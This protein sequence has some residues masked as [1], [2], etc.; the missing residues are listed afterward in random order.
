MKYWLLLLLASCTSLKPAEPI[1]VDP[2]EFMPKQV[3]NDPIIVGDGLD[4]LQPLPADNPEPKPVPEEASVVEDIPA[5]PPEQPSITSSTELVLVLT[6]C[7]VMLVGFIT[8][9]LVCKKKS[10]FK[11]PL[12]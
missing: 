9:G 6:C 4:H 11:D 5:I 3:I 7:I 12:A 10:G 2:I 1:R 8:W